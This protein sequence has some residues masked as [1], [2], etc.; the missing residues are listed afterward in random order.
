M[1]L[2]D[3]SHLIEGA[4]VLKEHPDQRRSQ[5]WVFFNQKD[6]TK[7]L[8]DE[9]NFARV[10]IRA[11][12]EAE[13]AA[14]YGESRIS[15]IFSRWLE[16]EGHVS[17]VTKRTLDRYRDNPRTLRIRADAKDRLTL[18]VG[19]V[20]DIL[21]R[22]I[23]DDRGLEVS[24]RWQVIAAREEPAGEAVGLELLEFEFTGRFGF[25][26][27][28]AAPI[29]ANATEQEKKSGAWYSDDLGKFPD[30][31]DGYQYQ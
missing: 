16:T 10:R 17:Q 28:D 31:T 30:G 21:T 14:Q 8:D 26:M 27:E 2:N 20:A 11:D 29:F 22:T 5:V 24:T 4:S 12:L 6:P 23:L 18:R 1:V 13:S 15:K 7:R 25:Y 19:E 3:V 9:A